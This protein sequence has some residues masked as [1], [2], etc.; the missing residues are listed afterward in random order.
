MF[1]KPSREKDQVSNW[2]INF[3]QNQ[4]EMLAQLKERLAVVED[5][6]AK[7]LLESEIEALKRS[8]EV[9]R[10]MVEKSLS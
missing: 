7:A 2:D 6:K 5:E 1:E 8:M 4:N 3:L 10:A 9:R